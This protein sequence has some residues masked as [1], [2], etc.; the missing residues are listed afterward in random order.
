MQPNSYALRRKR[1]GAALVIVLALVVLLTGLIV[2]FFSR[3]VTERQV[4]SIS[5]SQAN[6]NIFAQGALDIIIGDLKQEIA[7]GSKLVSPASGSATIYQPKSPATA[8]PADSGVTRVASGGVE[9]DGLNNLVKRSAYGQA[10]YTGTDYA[11]SGPSRAASLPTTAASLNGRFISRARWNKPLLIPKANLTSDTDAAPLAAFTE[12]D[13][14]LVARDGGNPTQ[15][16]SSLIVSAA[17]ATAVTGRYAYTIYD[18]G[19]LL[20][21]NVA[22]YP[23]GGISAQLAYKDAQAFAD[24][25]QLKDSAGNQV[26]TQAQINALASWRNYATLQPTGTFPNYSLSG[27]PALANYSSYVRSNT[28]GFLSVSNKALYSGQSDKMF[29]SR[30]E[31]LSLFTKGIATN[32]TE[33]A[34]LQ[35]ALQFFTTFSRDLNQPSYIP[36]SARPKI[37]SDDG[38]NYA[39]G[40]DSQTDDSK[41]INPPFLKVRAT[42]A[43]TRNDGTTAV[44]NEPLV[45]KRFALNRLAWL[46][47]KG[48]SSTRNQSDTDIQALI[49]NGIS[50]TFMQRGDEDQVYKYFGLYWDASNKCWVYNHSSTSTPGSAPTTNG[51]IMTLSQVAAL[52]GSNGREPDFVELLKASINVGAVGKGANRHD[53]ISTS[54][55]SVSAISGWTNWE[56]S[57]YKNDINTDYAVI[58]I[59]ANLVDQFDADGY[60]TTI[61]FDAG[62]GV[63]VKEFYGVENLPYFY[64]TRV[65]IIML[66]APAPYTTG[67]AGYF[68]PQVT[69]GSSSDAATDGLPVGT[70]FALTDPGLIATFLEPEVWN[71]HDANSSAGSP[72]PGKSGAAEFRLVADCASGIKESSVT[73]DLTGHG[74][75][76][77]SFQYSTAADTSIA[78]P[79][80]YNPGY[81]YLTSSNTALTFSDNSGALFREPTLLIKPACPNGSQLAMDSNN[82]LV[83]T[84][85]S[86]SLLT[87]Y[88]KTDGGGSPC[89]TSVQ[90]GQ[91]YVGIFLGVAPAR[92]V[93]SGSDGLSYV[94]TADSPAKPIYQNLADTSGTYRLQYKDSSG[95]WRTYDQKVTDILGGGNSVHWTSANNI[96]ELVGQTAFAVSIDPR[97]PRFGM[98]GGWHYVGQFSPYNSYAPASHQSPYEYLDSTGTI[99]ASSRLENNAGDGLCLSTTGMY[100]THPGTPVV[101]GLPATAGWYPGNWY[102]TKHTNFFRFGLCSQ[103]DPNFSN[104]G[105]VN[106]SLTKKSTLYPASPQ[107]QYYTDPDGVARR[108]MAGYVSGSSV[109]G[110]PMAIATNT[111]VS[112]APAAAQYQSR[113]I[114]LNR[115][116]R[117]VAELGAVFSGTPWKNLD[118]FAPE[119]GYA[120]L[121]DVFCVQDSDNTDGL[122]AGKVN[123]NTRQPLVLQSILSGAYQDEESYLSSPPQTALSELSSAVASSVA[124]KLIA[125][126]SD[127]ATPGKG[128]LINLSELVGKWV[129]SVSASSGGIDGSK[130]YDGFSSDISSI[131]S[132]DALHNIARFRESSLRALANAGTARVWNLMVDMVVQTGRYPASVQ[133]KASPL[134]QFSVEGEQRYWVHLAIDRSTGQVI[135]KQIEVVKE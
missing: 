70:K 14:I 101:A 34:T 17:S 2:A 28:K 90:N 19:G 11:T 87:G 59:A 36:D 6:V 52:S 43:F 77:T 47:Y 45:K 106:S 23:S 62:G 55:W 57:Q 125:R 82:G 134:S 91:N 127:T 54:S 56:H 94:L 18:V 13:W 96:A 114:V 67:T 72:R 102:D 88:L 126:T 71:P 81:I 51:S 124:A 130:S 64:R 128:P 80:N 69:T 76:F 25:T 123:L 99:L 105:L 63:G 111:G 116:F 26:L 131:F 135:D 68:Y 20:D 109:T 97:T 49:N 41:N 58:Q 33:R 119:S 10:F 73:A 98:G 122:I 65:G 117:S 4:S 132:T 100:T 66:R 8:I 60:P 21:A 37:V 75:G 35:N 79:F 46:T 120:P 121:L 110:L 89:V 44:E 61:R 30:Q 92:W 93:A 38:G 53:A 129:G 74:G 48:V 9:S 29:A 133:T 27:T 24:L 86:D 5:A 83:Q 32:A 104:D 12:P 78:F 7:D 39:Y 113:P 85:S 40:G 31:M 108:A 1:G 115:P 16:D 103:N 84:F 3:V 107:Y 22:G 118:M 95:N 50:W 15:W 112:P 42:S